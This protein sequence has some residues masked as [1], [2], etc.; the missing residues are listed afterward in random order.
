[1]SD[2]RK[3]SQDDQEPVEDD[4]DDADDPNVRAKRIVDKT[5]DEDQD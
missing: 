2:E 5:A 3:P 4:L 1:M